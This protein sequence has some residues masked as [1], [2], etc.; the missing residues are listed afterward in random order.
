MRMIG[1]RGFIPF[2]QALQQ[3][4]SKCS[5]FARAGLRD[6]KHILTAQD[7]RNGLLLDIRG[8]MKVGF[9]QHVRKLATDSQCQEIT[10]IQGCPYSC[11]DP[12]RN[13]VEAEIIGGGIEDLSESI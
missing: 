8:V 12:T 5:R 11:L 2:M 13:K 9:C 1:L 7:G 6:A 3:W 4:K 10:T